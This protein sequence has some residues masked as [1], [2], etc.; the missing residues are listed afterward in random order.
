MTANRE[1]V[2]DPSD[3][4]A[5]WETAAWL[6]SRQGTGFRSQKW[7]WLPGNRTARKVPSPQGERQVNPPGKA[8]TLPVPPPHSTGRVDESLGIRGLLR[9]KQIPSA[10]RKIHRG[11]IPAP[12]P[13]G[14][15]TESRAHVCTHVHTHTHTRC[16]SS[17][18]QILEAGGRR[19]G[20]GQLSSSPNLLIL[21][22]ALGPGPAESAHEGGDGWGSKSAGPEQAMPGSSP[23][24]TGPLGPQ[25][26][27]LEH[28]IRGL[29]LGRE[30]P[31][32]SVEVSGECQLL[33]HVGHMLCCLTW[34]QCSIMEKWH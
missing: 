1:G 31:R 7:A 27:S 34:S 20:E 26:T 16:I 25:R 6:S 30:G 8:N 14:L 12:T 15:P 29:P 9:T 22:E 28:K 2:G 33:K 13:S 5:S 11:Q 10:H 32:E 23:A 19:D 18:T 21:P 3:V 17:E 24:G 4:V